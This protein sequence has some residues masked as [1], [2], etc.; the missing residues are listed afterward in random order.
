MHD[1]HQN[2]WLFLLNDFHNS[3]KKPTAGY[4]DLVESKPCKVVLYLYD[5]VVADFLFIYFDTSG[6]VKSCLHVLCTHIFYKIQWRTICF[7]G[8]VKATEHAGDTA[9]QNFQ[10]LLAK[11]EIL[12]H[13]QTLHLQVNLIM[14]I[15]TLIICFNK[16]K[17]QIWIS[18]HSCLFYVLLWFCLI[19]QVLSRILS[20]SLLKEESGVIHLMIF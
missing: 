20:K 8:P 7:Q 4:V 14:N 11:S 3:C 9:L 13:K 10:G 17:S 15:Q 2:K 16:Q 6:F 18:I 1:E 12:H 5:V 19:N